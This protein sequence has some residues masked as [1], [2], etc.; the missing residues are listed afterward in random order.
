MAGVKN[1]GAKVLVNGFTT[2]KQ[3]GQIGC[4]IFPKI[5]YNEFSNMCAD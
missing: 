3:L 4:C 2:C 5:S 1:E